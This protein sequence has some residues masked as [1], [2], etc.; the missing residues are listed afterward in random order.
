MEENA[1][2][3]L[4]AVFAENTAKIQAARKAGDWDT[5]DALNERQHE[6]NDTLNAIYAR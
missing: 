1:I 4:E 6:I 3:K 2:K 5:V